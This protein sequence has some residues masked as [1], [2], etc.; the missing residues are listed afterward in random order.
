MH[1]AG[2]AESGYTSYMR[3]HPRLS[4]LDGTTGSKKCFELAMAIRHSSATFTMPDWTVGVAANYVYD[5]L[6]GPAHRLDVSFHARSGAPARSMPHGLI[7]AWLSSNAVARSPSQS[8][9]RR[10]P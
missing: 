4:R 7:G 6:A 5:R 2:A 8:Q 3:A 1:S 9:S 10:G